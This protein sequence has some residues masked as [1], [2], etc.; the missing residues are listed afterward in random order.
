MQCNLNSATKEAAENTEEHIAL[1]SVDHQRN[2]ERNKK[3]P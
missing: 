3:L 2:E 1:L